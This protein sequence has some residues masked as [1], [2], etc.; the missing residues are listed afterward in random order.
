MRML[1]KSIE[2]IA[3]KL[4]LVTLFLALGGAA[5]GGN[6]TY[7][8]PPPAPYR[9][10]PPVYRPPANQNNRTYVTPGSRSTTGVQPRVSPSNRPYVTPGARSTTGVQPRGVMP[11]RPQSTTN[12]T[13]KSTVTR[14]PTVTQKQN[15]QSRLAKLQ[16]GG[17]ANQNTP[18]P[19][20]TTAKPNPQARLSKLSDHFNEK[21]GATPPD[22]SGNPPGGGNNSSNKPPGGGLT[23]KFN[24]ASQ[25]GSGAKTPPVSSGVVKPNL[26]KVNKPGPSPAIVPGKLDQSKVV[27][28]QGKTNA[29][30][31]IFN[32]QANRKT[33]PPETPEK[34]HDLPGWN[35]PKPTPT[36]PPG[37][38]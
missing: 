27:I 21:S 1:C 3:M 11:T 28:G 8:P 2:E 25:P 14:V 24:A 9:P 15:V 17:A 13:N 23:P 20:T 37:P 29:V 22:K 5:F 7:K 35:P 18:K 6:N 36:P 38:K 33:D 4:H 30:T 34:K 26:A 19:T 12:S 31:P 10:P 32:S 16:S